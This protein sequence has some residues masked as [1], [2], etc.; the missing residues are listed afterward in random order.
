MSF[1]VWSETLVVVELVKFGSNIM[2]ARAYSDMQ[3]KITLNCVLAVQK[4]QGW[5]RISIKQEV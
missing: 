1:V 3:W 4:I 5:E 2:L